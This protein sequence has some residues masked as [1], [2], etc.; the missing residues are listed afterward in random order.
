MKGTRDLSCI[1]TT[2]LVS[3]ARERPLTPDEIASLQA[4][5]AACRHC[6]GARQ[7]FE[8][9]FRGIEALLRADDG[10]EYSP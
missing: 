1:D 10:A 9:L 6:Q 5:I 7:Q 3:D 8:V 2:W 4:H